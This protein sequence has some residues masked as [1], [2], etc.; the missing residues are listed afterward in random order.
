[1]LGSL[2]E[3]FSCTIVYES[4]QKIIMKTLILLFC[5]AF[6]THAATAQSYISRAQLKADLDSMYVIINDIHP[7]MFAVLPQDEFEAML[8]NAKLQL[9][10]SMTVFE[11]YNVIAPLVA[12]LGD[13]HTSAFFPRNQLRDYDIRIFPFSVM[14]N[15]RDSSVVVRRDFSEAPGEIPVG[16]E[17]LAINNRC[18]KEVVGRMMAC[19]SG[20][21]DFFRAAM[22]NNLFPSLLFTLY[23]EEDFLVDFQHEDVQA[24]RSVTG[25]SVS[26]INTRLRAMA[27]RTRPDY[28]ISFDEENHIAIIDF[29]RF[30]DQDRMREFLDSA[31]TLIHEKGINDLIIDIRENGGGQSRV[32]D[33]FFQYISPVPFLQFG[34]VI[35]RVSQRMIDFYAENYNFQHPD[36]IGISSHF[37]TELHELREN[38]L[39]F[40]G[41]IIMLTSNF[42]F[43]SAAGFAW[44]FKYFEMG[45]IVGEETG[46]LAVCFG[47]VIPQPLSNSGLQVGVSH[48]KF[49][50]YGATDENTHGTIPDYEVPANE[51][52]DF[53]VKMILENRSVNHTN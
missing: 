10:D 53:A 51:A 35:V 32:G 15:Y 36:T 28:S 21:K 5:M 38:P 12:S 37:E 50:Q 13:G 3:F 14:V 4:N 39:R 18:I 49:Y 44:A 41:N 23:A 52:M 30:N 33:V 7:D 45:T 8:A 48:K 1:M 31:F 20:E 42:S 46:G 16:A 9:A 43:S 6:A 40:H 11:F 47:D 29:L 27:F 34:G 24:Q 22:V 26:G 25:S 17:L 2:S 19:V